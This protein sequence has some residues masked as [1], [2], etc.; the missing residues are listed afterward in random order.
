[1]E[2]LGWKKKRLSVNFSL[3]WKMFSAQDEINIENETSVNIENKAWKEMKCPQLD[4]L[5]IW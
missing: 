3:G 5:L 2:N 4:N 1:M